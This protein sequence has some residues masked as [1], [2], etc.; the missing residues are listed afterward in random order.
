[1]FSQI[2][3][4]VDLCTGD[5]NHAFFPFIGIY[6]NLKFWRREGTVR[7]LTRLDEMDQNSLDA[8]LFYSFPG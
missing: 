7:V 4:D 2:Q 1:M 3:A 5:I 6:I 8:G